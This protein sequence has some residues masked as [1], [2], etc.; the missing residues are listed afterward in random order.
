MTYIYMEQADSNKYGTLK[1]GLRSQFTLDNDQYPRDMTKGN[2]VLGNHKWDDTYKEHV[3]KQKQKNNSNNNNNNR[4]W[5]IS[6][7]CTDAI[8]VFF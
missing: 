6:V 8:F 3:K 5:T 2:K 4:G 1:K 7:F